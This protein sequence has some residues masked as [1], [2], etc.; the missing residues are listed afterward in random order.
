MET[1]YCGFGGRR[2]R[3]STVQDVNVYQP[4]SFPLSVSVALAP[5]SEVISL[6]ML[7]LAM[8]GSM[9]MCNCVLMSQLNCSRI[10]PVDSDNVSA[11]T[12]Y[13]LIKDSVHQLV[14]KTDAQDLGGI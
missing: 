4:V 1:L 3:Y 10:A 11:L 7:L 13:V 9:Q 2:V 12:D 5:G 6:L 8:V 14:F